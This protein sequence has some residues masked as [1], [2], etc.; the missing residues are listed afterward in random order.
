MT[1]ELKVRVRTLKST[2][3]IT[4]A[5]KI[6]AATAFSRLKQNVSVMFGFLDSLI[7][8]SKQAKK[9]RSNTG[10][11]RRLLIVI[12]GDRGLCGGYN[13]AV[14]KKASLYLKEFPAANVAFIGVKAVLKGQESIFSETIDDLRN[15]D[16]LSERLVALWDQ[17]SAI[18]VIYTAFYSVYN[19]QVTLVS[20]YQSVEGAAVVQPEVLDET[21]IDILPA[22]YTATVMRAMINAQLCEFSSRMLSMDNATQNA[23]KMIEMLHLKIN[24]MRQAMITKELA[25]TVSGYI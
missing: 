17:Y 4:S 23:E 24:K 6:V 10:S 2:Y 25:E 22:I 19:Q 3:K 7:D 15:W 16:V 20:V 8:L 12:G 18:D 11:G 21:T 13:T 5:M 9:S 14:R 1:K